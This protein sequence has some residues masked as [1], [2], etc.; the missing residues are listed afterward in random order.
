MNWDSPSASGIISRT[1][2]CS[3]S[4]PDAGPTSYLFN[5]IYQ[6][7]FETVRLKNPALFAK[8]QERLRQYR[9]IY[10]QKSYQVLALRPEFKGAPPERV[11]RCGV[12]QITMP[13]AP[14]FHTEAMARPH[15]LAMGH[16]IP[17]A[18]RNLV[19]A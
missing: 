17:L 16:Q 1:I 18:T 5:E 8:L 2:I 7:R 15:R 13:V 11:E 12:P 3:A 9:V 19:T 14:K 4:K 10:D 6:L